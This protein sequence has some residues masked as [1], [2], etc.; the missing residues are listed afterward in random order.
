MP[1]RFA[2]TVD[3]V[4]HP[5]PAAQRVELGSHARRS[6]SWWLTSLRALSDYWVLTKPEI[7]FLI[8]ITTAGGFWMASDLERFSWL[9]LF[10][11]AAGTVLVASGAA[12]IGKRWATRRDQSRQRRSGQSQ[13]RRLHVPM[14]SKWAT[15]RH[16]VAPALAPRRKGLNITTDL[17]QVGKVVT[18]QQL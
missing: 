4:A 8:A 12:G 16:A 2:M 13:H 1:R 14:H 10:H 17:M 7:N 9:T 15:R 6:T 5:A 3:P 18:G 11:T